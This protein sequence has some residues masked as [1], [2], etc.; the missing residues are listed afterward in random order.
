MALA[1]AEPLALALQ[2]AGDVCML[3]MSAVGDVMVIAVGL[4]KVQPLESVTETV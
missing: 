2:A 1:V 3:T 4:V